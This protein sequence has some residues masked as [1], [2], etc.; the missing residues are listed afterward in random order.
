M[1][2]L[3]HRIVQVTSLPAAVVT[4]V[5]AL[6]GLS[7]PASAQT[8]PGE[9]RV[10][11][12][13][14]TTRLY[15]DKTWLDGS[16]PIWPLNEGICPNQ[17]I[18]VNSVYLGRDVRY[19]LGIGS[20]LGRGSFRLYL[21]PALGDL[22]IPAP[23]DPVWHQ[24]VDATIE[25]SGDTR[26]DPQHRSSRYYKI[27]YRSSSAALAGEVRVDCRGEG[28]QRYC[29]IAPYPHFAG[30]VIRYEFD[31]PKFP[32]PDLVAILP[33]TEPASGDSATEPGAVLQFDRRLR[34]WLVRIEQG[35]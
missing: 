3:R 6:T 31:Q 19:V 18:Q 1:G 8:Q 25:M 16:M 5:A 30:L 20:R 34:E 21:Q 32:V 4:A 7:Q 33:A 27:T 29:S 17:P 13:L 14:P 9:C 15:V 12:E 10:V 24:P 35:F 22:P 26:I 28:G 2:S 11:L 23:N